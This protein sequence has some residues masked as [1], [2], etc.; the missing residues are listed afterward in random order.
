V[1]ANEHEWERFT[2]IEIALPFIANF[3]AG[4]IAGVSEIL[5]FYPLGECPAASLFLAKYDSNCVH[6]LLDVVRSYSSVLPIPFSTH[7]T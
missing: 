5:T 6:P 3:A 2:I 1:A 7:N 4:A